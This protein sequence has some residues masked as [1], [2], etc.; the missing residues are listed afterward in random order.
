MLRHRNCDVK[1]LEFKRNAGKELLVDQR[2]RGEIARHAARLIV[3]EGISGFAAAKQKAAR[4]LGVVGQGLLPDNLEIDAAIRV[5]E[6]IFHSDTQPL[7]CCALRHGAIGAMRWLKAF[8]PWLVGGVLTGTAN[9]FSH[10]ELEIILED[11][12]Q[13]EIFFLNEGTRF[14]T[15]VSRVS[16][17]HKVDYACTIAT[18]ELTFQDFAVFIMLYPHHA[19]REAHH[20]R[21]KLP[22]ARARIAEVEIM[23]LESPHLSASKAAAVIAK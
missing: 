17:P 18:Y 5:Y 23:M 13:L 21:N 22:R 19:L 1:R 2:M 9:R 4:Q 20:S 15:R 3:E 12:K 11:S 6:S 16:L 7:E 8:S 10:I 14:R